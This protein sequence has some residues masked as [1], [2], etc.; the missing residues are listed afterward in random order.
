[1]FT[2]GGRVKI[3][4]AGFQA[5][6]L[7]DFSVVTAKLSMSQHKGQ[8]Y[9]ILQNL[10]TGDI[11]TA[12]T[13]EDITASPNNANYKLYTRHE[14]KTIVSLLLH[15]TACENQ[16]IDGRWREIATYICSTK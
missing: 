13:W 16:A 12:V 6:S 5:F 9:L 15:T 7:D 2:Q 11:L 8:L 10:F 3:N 1:M 4:I 14:A